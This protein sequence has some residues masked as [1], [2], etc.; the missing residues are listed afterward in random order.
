M[1]KDKH[2]GAHCCPESASSISSKNLTVFEAYRAR[3]RLTRRFF[4]RT[5]IFVG[6]EIINSANVFKQFNTVISA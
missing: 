5:V 3:V 6:I 2:T 1:R 4:S